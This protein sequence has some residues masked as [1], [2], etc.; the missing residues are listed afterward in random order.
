[1]INYSYKYIYYIYIYICKGGL[2]EK[3]YSKLQTPEARL[4]MLLG[5]AKFG[6]YS[7]SAQVCKNFQV[8]DLILKKKT[9]F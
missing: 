7:R 3:L 4:A 2:A 1:M 6:Q 9:F 5:T 8:L